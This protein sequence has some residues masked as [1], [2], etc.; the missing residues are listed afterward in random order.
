MA[1]MMSPGGDGGRKGFDTGGTDVGSGN[2]SGVRRQFLKPGDAVAVIG[3]GSCGVYTCRTLLEAGLRPTVFEQS[4]GVGGVWRRDGRGGVAYDCLR[5][6]SSDLITT[7]PGYPMQPT[8]SPFPHH[9]EIRKYIEGYTK[10]F[11]LEKYIRL[12]TEVTSVRPI[13]NPAAPECPMWRVR[14]RQ[15]PDDAGLIDREA[16]ETRPI[17]GSE[18]EL[19]FKAVYICTGQFG[20]GSKWPELPGKERFK[21]GIVHSRTYRSN[22]SYRGKR[23]MVIGLGNS[24]LD[25]ALDTSE[26]AESVVVSVRRGST[27]VLAVDDVKGRPLDIAVHTRFNLYGGDKSRAAMAFLGTPKGKAEF[28]KDSYVDHGDP[29]EV[30]REMIKAGMPPPLSGQGSQL[31]QV[32]DR[33]TVLKRLR[34]GRIRF[35]GGISEVKE[36]SV[37]LVN[38]TEVPVDEI[39]CCTGYDIFETMHYIDPE[40]LRPVQKLSPSGRQW[41]DLYKM[42]LHPTHR[43]FIFC[44]MSTT[45][46]NEALVGEMQARW[47][48]AVLTGQADWPSKSDVQE[49]CRKRKERID[50]VDPAY[51]R[52]VRYVV[53]MDDLARDIGCLPK[54]PPLPQEWQKG[55]PFVNT[56]ATKEE[57]YAFN[58]WFGPTTP[59]HWRL[60]GPGK[61]EPRSDAKDYVVDKLIPGVKTPPP[62]VPVSWAQPMPRPRL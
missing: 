53:Y 21:G 14:V 34:E 22:E 37:V 47:A 31:G 56:P 4:H 40:V 48:T 19:E 41:F 7:A 3:G 17:P 29:L 36:R 18:E 5:T 38:G 43:N 8:T 1:N 51:T 45:D 10:H 15:L 49:F 54:V 32:K 50:A 30:Q 57:R 59:A 44:G 52:F 27:R 58:L 20:G 42:L 60:D 16:Y 33:G 61:W 9:T 13:P 55:A 6:N 39:V 25:L 12:L 11:G 23:V 46:A 24:A 62:E 26:V 28:A 2:R 35:C